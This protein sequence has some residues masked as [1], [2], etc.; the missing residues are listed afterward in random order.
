MLW[1][2]SAAMPPILRIGAWCVKEVVLA[3]IGLVLRLPIVLGTTETY[4]H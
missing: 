4:W 2:V 3:V 1:L